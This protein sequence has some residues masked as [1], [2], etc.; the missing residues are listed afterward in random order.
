MDPAS[1]RRTHEY[2]SGDDASHLRPQYTYPPPLPP[3]QN[4]GGVNSPSAAQRLPMPYT[5]SSGSGQWPHSVTVANNAYAVSARS[6][7]HVSADYGCSIVFDSSA[8][9][10]YLVGTLV[11]TSSLV[12]YGGENQI[13]FAYH[14]C[15]TLRSPYTLLTLSILALTY[16]TS[17]SERTAIIS[18]ATGHSIQC[19]TSSERQHS[20]SSLSASVGHSRSTEPRT[21]R[22]SPR[23]PSSQKCVS[24][25]ASYA[26]A[27]EMRM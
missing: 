7:E 5:A 3:S 22:A 14:V 13:L 4:L 16:R 10:T 19:T 23:R 25:F 26:G 15:A 18:S 24:S 9:T 2:S 27:Q 12:F 8:C 1:S 21:S 17:Q 11:A 20:P 6:H